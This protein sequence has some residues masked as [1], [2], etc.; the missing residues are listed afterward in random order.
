MK[1]ALLLA[2]AAAATLSLLPATSRAGFSVDVNIGPPAPVVV[3][4]PPP[5]PGYIWSPGYWRWEE[6]RHVWFNGYW[7][8]ER[9][10]SRWV[11]DRW[12]HRGRRYHYEPGHFER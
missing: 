10:G 1:R 12:D 5:R 4:T 3:E 2:S 9:P 7:V 8:P 11:P 6:G